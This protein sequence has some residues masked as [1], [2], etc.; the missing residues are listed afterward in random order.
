MALKNPETEKT[1]SEPSLDLL[2]NRRLARETKCVRRCRTSGGTSTSYKE[3]PRVA[4]FRDL[5]RMVG[6]YDRGVR[7]ACSPVLT[8]HT[9]SFAGLPKAFDG[10]R[11]LHLSDFH[12]GY[13]P[14]IAGR[15]CRLVGDQ[16][17]DLCLMTGDFRFNHWAPC[18]TVYDGVRT[19]L[20]HFRPRLG[21]HAILGN[22]DWSEF[23]VRFRALGLNTLVNAHCQLE[24]DGE[25]VW[26]AGVDDPHEF[27]C[28]SLYHAVKGIPEGAFTVLMAHSPEIIRE[29]EKRGVDLYLCGH[30]HGGQMC[31][32]WLGPI[33]INARCPRRYALG[34]PWRYG[35]L[36]GFTNRGF[37]A[38]TLP[39]RYNCPPEAVLL[40]LRRA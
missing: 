37:G 20:A 17:V 31:L 27:R 36:H 6:I 35:D 18:R 5:L 30:T 21:S 4:L 2:W 26:L 14:D 13:D 38:S 34:G 33:Y 28:N 32:P 10:L 12:F 11:I 1:Y 29:A 39:I 9:F 15:V 19:L 22:N 23:A 16:E 24:L 7:N 8:R 3:S 25:S 40:E